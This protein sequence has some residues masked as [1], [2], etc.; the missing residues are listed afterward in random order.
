MAS[1]FFGCRSLRK[2]RALAL[3]L[4]ISCTAALAQSSVPLVAGPADFLTD[5]G[6][7]VYRGVV[8][9]DGRRLAASV[10]R[11]G[12]RHIE[13]MDLSQPSSLQAVTTGVGIDDFPC[14]T[15]DSVLI[16]FQ[17]TRGVTTKLYQVNPSDRRES[18]LTFGP[19]DD[20]HPRVS[21]S[22]RYVAFDSNRSGN[23]DLWVMDRAT[24][25]LA[26][27]T[28]D[29]EADFYPAWAPNDRA[30][31]FT[32][33]RS[34]RFE[35]W[36][37]P[38]GR[39]KTA[40]RLTEGAG[41]QAHPDWSGSGWIS[42][43][44][45][46]NG[47]VHA[48]LINVSGP[49]HETVLT[50]G[51]ATH[52]FARFIP[53]SQNLVAQVS[54]AGLVGMKLVSAA[55]LLASTR[56]GSSIATLDSSSIPPIRS[57]AS[58]DSAVIPPVPSGA[59]SSQTP[60][61]SRLLLS[62]NHGSDVAPNGGSGLAVVDFFPQAQG[63]AASL[64][65]SIS[66]VFNRSLDR[67]MEPENGVELYEMDRKVPI[68]GS[69]NPLLKRVDVVPKAGLK[70]GTAYRVVV[71]GSLRSQEGGLLGADFVFGFK[72]A[73]PS[74]TE[75]FK[76]KIVPQEFHLSSIQPNRGQ[77]SVPCD[78]KLTV[79]FS[80][81]LDLKTLDKESVRLF[82]CQGA[83]VPGEL[84][85]PPGDQTLTLS[86]YQPLAEDQTYQVSVSPKIRC[87]H[88]EII[89]ETELS[90]EFHTF[91][92]R[93]FSVV[94]CTPKVLEEPRARIKIRFSRPID[95]RSF[96]RGQVALRSSDFTFSGRTILTEGNEAVEFEP[97]QR[98]PDRQTLS[99]LLPA[100]LTDEEGK[101]LA[102]GMPLKVVTK[103]LPRRVAQ[104]LRMAQ[105][106][107]NKS[108]D[109][110]SQ[111]SGIETLRK[112]EVVLSQRFPRASST[113]SA[114]QRGESPAP[115]GLAS[116]GNVSHSSN[117]RTLRRPNEGVVR[118][119][120]PIVGLPRKAPS[121]PS[122]VQVT[123]A[124]GQCQVDGRPASRQRVA[125]VSS[126]A[127][128]AAA[129]DLSRSLMERGSVN[130]TRRVGSAQRNTRSGSPV[131]RVS[132][133]VSIPPVGLPASMGRPF[134][135]RAS[136][137]SPSPVRTDPWVY[138]GLSKLNA[139]GFLEAGTSVRLD[140]KVSLPRLKLAELVNRAAAQYGRLNASDRLLVRRLQREF[141]SELNAL[142]VVPAYIA[143]GRSRQPRGI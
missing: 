101:S 108:E 6:L 97:Y 41:Q 139:Q 112:G 54:E 89:P 125:D 23:Y 114:P 22:G 37:Q 20:L 64:D 110:R 8:S 82:D 105:R 46:Q 70:P 98:L 84:Y 121:R 140:G 78:Q 75:S 106:P 76:Y 47:A 93:P 92:N 116:R 133:G 77:R 74:V 127:G 120:L 11:N 72:T 129:G 111:A 131:A 34:G 7:K 16:V 5:T 40:V 38:L 115:L 10:D 91:S 113:S 51:R 80:H 56:S 30:L 49:R 32:S 117:Q 62:K 19:G 55:S 48:C 44:S 58:L 109:G 99:V 63:E 36:I 79:V 1:T 87:T 39:G 59:A 45:D 143:I 57:G 24:G 14:W 17:S 4:L 35:I 102:V 130:L 26:Q 50:S 119:Q 135:A 73:T 18:P 118:S 104:G 137:T 107:R 132:M 53:G 141:A 43:D 21:H 95:V 126:N 83:Q 25:K 134:A 103:F 94:A 124:A 33:A 2:A 122:S 96:S 67:V 27:A 81:T 31:A 100:G 136:L 142:G 9:P 69:Y 90:W 71:R 138:A 66:V 3:G 88:G 42:Y 123:N 128:S 13:V 29:P 61:Q 12:A 68:M 86:P 15:P 28:N 60:T 65:T 85:A 52:E